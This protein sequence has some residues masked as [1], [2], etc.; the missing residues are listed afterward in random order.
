MRYSVNEPVLRFAVVAAL[1]L[2]TAA[3]GED[4]IRGLFVGYTPHEQYEYHLKQAGLDQTALGRDWIVAAGRAVEHPVDINSPYREIS[5]LDAREALAVGY[6]IKLRRGQR[7]VA[8]FDTESDSGFLVF[9]DMFVVPNGSDGDPILLTSADSL[10]HEVEYVARRD[11]DY[12]VRMQPE[13]LRGGRYEITIIT[14]ASL[15]FPVS[16]HDTTAIK[17]RFGDSRDGGRRDHHGVDIF[18][19]RGTPVIASAKGTV[20]STRWN[21]LGGRVVWLRDELGRSLYYAHLDSQV[22]RRGDLVNAGDTVGFVGNSG[23]ART[24]PPH[25]HF[26]VYQRGPSD[27]YPALYQPP[28][29]PAVF[30]G[31]PLMIGQL[32][33]VS[34]DRAR[35]RSLPTTRSSVVVELQLHTPLQVVAGSGG[36]YRVNL[37]D[38]SNGFI[39]A[40]L[41]ES[42]ERPIRSAVVADGGVLLSQ[43]QH[44]AEELG[45]LAAGVEVPVLGAYGDFVLVQMPSGLAGWLSLE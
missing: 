36:W 31:D 3:C 25:L 15:A 40:Q 21:K 2:L 9:L 17:S 45:D 24:T 44:A 1:G 39:A 11:G 28:L 27:P 23:N 30:S 4:S 6:R 5:Y 37:P 14:E 42:V 33:R 19:P 38:G 8:R 43:P 22:V 7:L 16:G 13:L 29:D 12:V 26:G 10:E 34:R 32:A 18:A 35:V 41:T 20:R